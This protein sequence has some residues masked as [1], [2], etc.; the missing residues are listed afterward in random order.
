MPCTSAAGRLALAAALVLVLATLST[1]TSG[2]AA[3][4]DEKSAGTGSP[5]SLA[6]ARKAASSLDTAAR[7]L[8][9]TGR[10]GDPS[11]TLALRDLFSSLPDLPGAQRRDAEAMLARPT[12]GARDPQGDGYAVP[13]R[14]LCGPHVC[15]HYVQRTSDAPRGMAWVRRT[16]RVMERVWRHQ[17]ETMGYRAPLRD[18]RRGGDSRFDVYL[19]DLGAH[20][21]YGYCA[22]EQRR[23]QFLA[24]GFCVLDDDF[25]REQFGSSPASTLRV[26]AAHEF[27]H[28]V[29]YAYDFA[30]DRWLLETTATWMEERFADDVDDNRQYLPHGQLTRPTLSLDTWSSDSLAQYGNW[31]FFEYLSARYGVSVVREIWQRAAAG[32]GSRDLYSLRALTRTLARRGDTFAS[33]YADFVA[34]NTM[35]RQTYPEGAAWPR[36]NLAGRVRLGPPRRSTVRRSATINHLASRTWDLVPGAGSRELRI[37]VRSPRTRAGS[38]AQVLVHRAGGVVRRSIALD[39][40]GDG[41]VTLPFASDRIRKVTL[42]LVNASV[43]YRCWRRSSWSCQGRA[44]DDGR[45]FAFEATATR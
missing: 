14:R 3:A 17:V 19:K 41:S 10:P 25:A 42:S 29:Q 11:P 23:Q 33:V 27:F 32:T 2:T 35:P 12:D 43:R 1:L 13:S 16:L 9:G 5:S 4:G 15:V 37:E 45:R 36:V 21:Y 38:V 8:A 26:T 28:A 30:E 20:G 22:A 40:A 18:R 34:A 31:V 44:R 39:E 6:S 7:V 24:S